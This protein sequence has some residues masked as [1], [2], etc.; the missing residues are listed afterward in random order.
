MSG[1]LNLSC[2]V[3]ESAVAAVRVCH[4][5][6]VSAAILAGQEFP[7][8]LQAGEGRHAEKG[9]RRLPAELARHRARE[10]DHCDGRRNQLCA[11]RGRDCRIR[12][13]R[14]G[15]ASTEDAFLYGRHPPHGG[16]VWGDQKPLNSL[17][18]RKLPEASIGDL[19]GRATVFVPARYGPH[20]Q[21][22]FPSR[23]LIH[24]KDQC[25]DCSACSSARPEGAPHPATALQ[26]APAE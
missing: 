19:A 10:A 18:R 15:G 21:S 7:R 22:N 26:P 14:Q 2:H 9:I 6:L 25:T 20:G 17:G 23:G 24:F 11:R 8:R 3:P 4:R 12:S 5:R 16:S 1:G 13:S